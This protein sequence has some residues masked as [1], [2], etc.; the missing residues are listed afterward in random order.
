METVV[1]FC[2]Y[3]LGLP[4]ELAVIAA[5]LRGGYRRYPFIF[6]YLVVDFLTTVMEIQPSLTFNTA[7][8]EQ[9]RFFVR[10]YWWNERIIQ[11]LI[12]MLVISLI[13]RVT[14]AM[15]PRRMLIGGLVL[16]TL[17]FAAISFLLHFDKSLPTSTWMTPWT[18]DLNFCAAILDL[19]LWAA[20]VGSRDRDY[21]L[22]M[23]SGALGVQFTG[24][25]IGQAM[26][27]MSSAVY[28]SSCFITLTN[29]IC[30]YIWWQTFRP[31]RPR[32]TKIPT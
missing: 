25:A 15:P 6:L 26:R 9:Q 29:L 32:Q 31:S 28:F 20:L 13:Y 8:A 12:F 22:L 21:Q 7:T 23:I 17:G 5:L 27:G 10:M 24:G 14:S 3:L 19:G 2:A 11:V 1:Q 16:G 18:R 30:L 4:L